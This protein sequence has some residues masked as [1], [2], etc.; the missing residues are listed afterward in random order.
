MLELV[1]KVTNKMQLHRLIIIPSQHYMFRAMFSPIIRSTLLYL[2][3][4]V[5]FTQVAAGWCLGRVETPDD[6]RKHCPKFIELIRNNKLTRVVA[7]FWL[8]S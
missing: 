8:F 5:V 3:L 7:S 2:Q 1:K 4:L 6:G